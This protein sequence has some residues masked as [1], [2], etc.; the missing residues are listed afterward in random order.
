MTAVIDYLQAMRE[1]DGT[2][3]SAQNLDT[4][5]HAMSAEERQQAHRELQMRPGEYELG[6]KV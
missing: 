1:R 6:E 3:E 5:W 4:L 2:I